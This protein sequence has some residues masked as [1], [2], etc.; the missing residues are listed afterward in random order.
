MAI[1]H[2]TNVPA[3]AMTDSFAPVLRAVNV[4]FSNGK[5]YDIF[6]FKHQ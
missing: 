6:I 5:C 4:A 1:S 2:S 3:Y